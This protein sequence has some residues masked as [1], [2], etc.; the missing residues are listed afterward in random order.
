MRSFR[1]TLVSDHY[2]LDLVDNSDI[3][4]ITSH[5]SSKYNIN[6]ITD[7]QELSDLFSIVFTPLLSHACRTLDI[8]L[9]SQIDH[10]LFSNYIVKKESIDWFKKR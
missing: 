2:L 4:A 6:D 10:Y 5:L 7:E 3:A 8:D 1:Q 9:Y